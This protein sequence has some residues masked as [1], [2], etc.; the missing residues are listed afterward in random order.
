L[1][2][3]IVYTLICIN[4]SYFS[5]SQSDSLSWEEQFDLLEAEMDSLSLY[6]LF[7]SILA[8]EYPMKYSE[9][10]TRLSYNSDVLSAGRNYGF[11]QRSIS[12]GL[13]YYHSSG[14]FA[15]YTGFI[16]TDS[17]FDYSLS[18][19]S[20][21]YLISKKNFLITPSYERWLY[22]ND[23]ESTLNNSLG[24]SISY[25]RK[26]G[27]VSL[28]YSFLFGKET[29]HRLIGTISGNVNLKSFWKFKKVRLNPSI[30]T[31]FGNSDVIV[32]LPES[33]IELSKIYFTIKSLQNTEDFITYFE[34]L[35]ARDQDILKRILDPESRKPRHQNRTP[36][37]DLDR[38]LE[39]HSEL[40]N[41]ALNQLTTVENRYGIMNYN[42]SLPLILQADRFS[43]MFSY[44][45]SMPVSL[46]G[47][48]VELENTSYFGASFTYRIPLNNK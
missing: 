41:L 10:N 21:G 5:Y 3:K 37:G 23:T 29:A 32:R 36:I 11:N 4:C 47:E 13:A 45:Y 19:F 34:S 8:E 43:F 44:S 35:D 6:N 24:S 39:T 31:F 46:P 16:D 30:T 20:A 9:F 28:D 14:L 7:E 15:D 2:K 12:P 33:D 17:T 25:T 22:H 42:F 1:L 40:E 38:F 27:F 26:R 18:I 48:I